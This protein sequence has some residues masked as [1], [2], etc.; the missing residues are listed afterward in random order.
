MFVEFGPN[1]NNDV[2]LSTAVHA[3]NAVRYVCD[4]PCGIRTLLDLPMIMASGATG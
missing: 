3:V 2:L 1:W 4:A